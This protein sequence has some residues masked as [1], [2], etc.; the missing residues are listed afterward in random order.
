MSTS[1]IDLDSF[2]EASIEVLKAFRDKLNA[3]SSTDIVITSPPKIQYYITQ[4]FTSV[5]GIMFKPLSTIFNTENAYTVIA[6]TNSDPENMELICTKF[7]NVP[8]LRK[9]LLI[10]PKFTDTAKIV[11]E[12]Y[13]LQIVSE[14][15]KFQSAQVYVGEFP[16]DFI[17][18]ENDFFLMPCNNAFKK[19]FLF[20]E[21]TDLY[22]SSRALAKIQYVYGRIP[23]VITVGE[24]AERVQRLMEGMLDQTETKKTDSPDIHSLLI[25]DRTADLITPL[26][27]AQPIE[28][29]Y[30][31][32]FGMKYGL[33]TKSNE[34]NI[35]I[36]MNDKDIIYKEYRHKDLNSGLQ[37][38][39][40]LKNQ[41]RIGGDEAKEFN[42]KKEI[43]TRN[44]DIFN[45]LLVEI[46]HNI[47]LKSC[48]CFYHMFE[49]SVNAELFAERLVSIY[50]DWKAALRILIIDSLFCYK[51]GLTKIY[52]SIQNE[53]LAEF[54]SKALEGL[55][56][57]DILKLISSENFG[58][59][60]DSIVNK[61]NLFCEEPQTDLSIATFGF[62]PISTGICEKIA[63]NTISDVQYL[64]PNTVTGAKMNISGENVEIDETEHRRIL[65]FF[66]GGVTQT[67]VS[68][69]K[70]MEVAKFDGKVQFIIGSTDSIG[71]NELIEEL[72][73]FLKQ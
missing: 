58:W 66:V 45:R 57:L 26:S 17:P 35:T 24:T 60:F 61:L 69:L 14:P 28:Q 9:A 25:F 16:A 54:G 56:N 37:Y 38:I 52:P 22:N 8:K 55:M 53:V 11:L 44:N 12:K 73:P 23:H 48:N 70:E 13:K 3:S 46:D 68:F 5:K 4:L 6:I 36:A 50:G 63:T 40:S 51:R 30:Y 21:T 19:L 1:F 29:L 42:S 72:C 59:D 18:V 34:S 10:I 67:E 2:R 49:H 39:S 7:Q 43:F 20:H 47:F 15:S 27:L 71:G 64:F 33:M 31:D 32:Y 62:T 65:V 41:A